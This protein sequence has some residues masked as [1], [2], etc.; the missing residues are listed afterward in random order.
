MVDASDR[1]VAVSIIIR[2]TDDNSGV[3]HVQLEFESPSGKHE[4]KMSGRAEY[5]RGSPTDVVY[6]GSARVLQYSEAGTW[7]IIW[8]YLRD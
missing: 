5:F 3:Q 6:S 1:V 7:N 8:I 2:A 4:A